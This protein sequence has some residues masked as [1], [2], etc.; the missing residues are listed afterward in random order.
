MS[1]IVPKHLYDE[2]FKKFEEEKEKRI[3]AE[4]KLVSDS[5]DYLHYTT[6]QH[7]DIRVLLKHENMN[8]L[9]PYFYSLG[10]IKL[11]LLTVTRSFVDCL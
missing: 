11:L 8:K 3:Q 5:F 6:G 7:A 10:S 9:M 1:G 4:E 2:L